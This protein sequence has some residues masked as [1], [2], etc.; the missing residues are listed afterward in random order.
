MAGQA[1]FLGLFFKTPRRRTHIE[2]ETPIPTEIPLR[3]THIQKDTPISNETP[4]RKT[5]T[6]KET[7]IPNEV[8]QT[9]PS[10]EPPKQFYDGRWPTSH[11][12]LPIYLRPTHIA[13]RRYPC[14]HIPGTGPGARSHDMGANPRSCI[15]AIP[16]VSRREEEK[17]GP[18]QT[19][20]NHLAS[21]AGGPG[22][23]SG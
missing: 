1:R 19:G 3:R 13:F 2:K 16:E 11:T 4:P 20:N 12:H 8:H 14:H 22:D 9:T 18:G 5:N 6:T 7:P 10:Q 17:A 23:N 21:R 15:P